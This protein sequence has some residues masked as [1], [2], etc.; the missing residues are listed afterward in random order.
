MEEEEKE[1]IKSEEI[2]EK[3][4]LEINNEAYKEIEAKNEMKINNQA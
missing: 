2:E 3:N 4:E 1:E